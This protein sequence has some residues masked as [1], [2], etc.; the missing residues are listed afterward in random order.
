MTY[1]ILANQFDGELIQVSVVDTLEPGSGQLLLVRE[2]QIPDL[3]KFEW[4]P[5]SLAFIEKNQSRWMSQIHFLE[6]IKHDELVG[7]YTLAET[8]VNVKIWLDKFKMAQEIFFD[9]P[10][11]QANLPLFELA[12]VL[13]PGRAAEILA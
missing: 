9:D 13:A 7:I 4:H 1:Y 11:M 2:G 10:E 12:G 6:R 3:E 5:G 8:D